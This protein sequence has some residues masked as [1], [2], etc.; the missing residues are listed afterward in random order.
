MVHYPNARIDIAVL[1]VTTNDEGTRI[2]EYDFTTPID[3]FMADVQ[4]NSLTK[5]QIELYGINEKTAHTKKAFYTK[6]NFMLAG[7]R[8]KVTYNDGKYHLEFNSNVFVKDVYVSASESGD[9]SDNFFCVLP[10]VTSAIVFEPE[11]KSKKDV[12]F[13]VHV[14]N[15]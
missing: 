6:S 14:Y 5:E 15:R 10:N 11:D 1:S 2:K 4:P 7:N 3:S 8:A 12:K 9:F 13:K